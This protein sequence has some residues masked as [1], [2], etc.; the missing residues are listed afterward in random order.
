MHVLAETFRIGHKVEKADQRY[1]NHNAATEENIN[2]IHNEA[3]IN[4]LLGNLSPIAKYLF[5]DFSNPY[6]QLKN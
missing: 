5:I 4:I 6:I 1:P 2:A 3:T